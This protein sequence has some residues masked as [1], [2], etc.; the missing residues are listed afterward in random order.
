MVES[1]SLEH[2]W[3]VEPAQGG[4][5]RGRK[6]GFDLP[7]LSAQTKEE[8]IS[9]TVAVAKLGHGEVRVVIHNEDGTTQPCRIYVNDP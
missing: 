9:R 5:W 4:G 7:P 8:A 6:R 1:M 3:D 2:V